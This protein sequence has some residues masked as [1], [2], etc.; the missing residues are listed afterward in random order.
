M[1]LITKGTLG[2]LGPCGRKFKKLKACLPAGLTLPF[3][4][5]QKG[6]KKSSSLEALP[7]GHH[8]K[9]QA[10]DTDLPLRFLFVMLTSEHDIFLEKENLT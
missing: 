5:D 8:S 9:K 10:S 7:Y 2:P 3:L 1:P 6:H 4:R